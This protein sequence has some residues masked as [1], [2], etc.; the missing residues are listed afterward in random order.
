MGNT[1]TGLSVPDEICRGVYYNEIK[2]HDTFLQKSKE[3]KSRFNKSSVEN[4]F[5]LL[6]LIDMQT[7]NQPLF[8]AIITSPNFKLD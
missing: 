7:Y 8:E 2:D 5:L 4:I 3:M 1:G 6:R